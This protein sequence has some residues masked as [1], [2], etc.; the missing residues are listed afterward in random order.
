MI[1]SFT[2][3]LADH[4]LFLILGIILPW[5]TISAQKQL[6]DIQ[7][8]SRM[9]RTLYIG[10]SI[11]LWVMALL[12]L[13]LWWWM[14]RPFSGLGLQWTQEALGFWSIAF[15][16]LFLFVYLLDALRDIL[17]EQGRSNVEEKLSAELNI[18]PRKFQTYL[19]F[20]PLALS[21]GICEEIVFRGYFIGYFVSL[22]GNHLAAQVAAIA[23]PALIFGVVHTYQ[24][25]QAIYKIVGMA[26]LF[27]TVYVL[28]GSIYLLI[29]LHFVVDLIGGA[30]GLFFPEEAATEIL[31]DQWTYPPEYWQEEE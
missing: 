20:I 19:F 22:F 17:T 9:R 10:N 11:G 21:A 26:V 6:K 18:L 27:G 8:D 14:G 2:L 31:D 1:E 4:I 16:V 29:I 28:S 12:V 30:I 24:G 15:F 3:H 23:I 13:G 7:F 5:R 25:P